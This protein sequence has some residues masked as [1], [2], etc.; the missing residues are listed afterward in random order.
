MLN[1][2]KFESHRQKWQERHEDWGQW[3]GKKGVFYKMLRAKDACSV[4]R[5]KRQL[6]MPKAHNANGGL[7]KFSSRVFVN[8]WLTKGKAPI[9]P[10]MA[11]L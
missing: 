4:M 8:Y 11:K 9:Y 6:T 1:F 10:S 5:F 2:L 3:R 7:L